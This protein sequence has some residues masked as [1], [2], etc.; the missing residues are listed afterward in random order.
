M[1]KTIYASAIERGS[2]YQFVYR[3]LRE[4]VIGTIE[5]ICERERFVKVKDINAGVS[6]IVDLNTV[7]KIR[8]LM[9]RKQ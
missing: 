5:R 1:P 4:P 9:L 8:Q 7:K 3:D 6:R 2:T